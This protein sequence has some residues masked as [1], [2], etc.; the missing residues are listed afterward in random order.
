M[1]RLHSLFLMQHRR[2]Q[3]AIPVSAPCVQAI[4]NLTS[5]VYTMLNVVLAWSGTAVSLATHASSGVKQLEKLI[6]KRLEEKRKDRAMRKAT[7][8]AEELARGQQSA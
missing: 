8:K 3:Y 5:S 1:S 7:Q 6:R 2:S 4:S